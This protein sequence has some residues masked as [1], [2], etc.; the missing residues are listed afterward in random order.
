[1]TQPNAMNTNS[2]TNYTGLAPLPEGESQKT[3]KNFTQAVI[4]TGSRHFT[5]SG[6]AETLSN[7]LK[8]AVVDA[9]ET[10][11]AL[12]D[13]NA[14]TF[15]KEAL[16]SFKQ[17]LKKSLT[18]EQ[19]GGADPEKIEFKKDEFTVKDLEALWSAKREEK[20][21]NGETLVQCPVLEW[22]KGADGKIFITL[23]KN[24]DGT[25][26]LQWRKKETLLNISIKGSGGIFGLGGKDIFFE[27]KENKKKNKKDENSIGGSLGYSSGVQLPNQKASQAQPVA[28]QLG[29]VD[30]DIDS[31]DIYSS[32]IDSSD[33]D[34][35]DID[36]SDIDSRGIDSRGIDSRG[37][38]SRGIDSRGIDSG[39]D[40]EQ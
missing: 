13:N 30:Q 35:S 10:D 22:E 27:I 25:P 31:S 9:K 33:I 24:A 40:D 26:A 15:G 36:S 18:T 20:C 38:D 2:T 11:P 1:M 7:G 21:I 5:G 17:S 32:D 37:I 3:R 12:K 4:N 23:K 34:S 39:D 19:L 28:Q 29:Q 16:E 14:G 8:A 6:R